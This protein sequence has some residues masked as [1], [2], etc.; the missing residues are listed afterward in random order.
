MPKQVATH[1]QIIAINEHLKKTLVQAGDSTLWEYRAG[2][3]DDTIAA[4]EGVSKNS[5]GNI[6]LKL[7]GKL[8]NQGSSGTD[9]EV[10]KLRAQLVMLTDAHNT[11]CD[12]FTALVNTLAL[13]KVVNVG[14]LK[15]DC[16]KLKAAMPAPVGGEARA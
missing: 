5:V 16:A 12:R 3:S 14:H 7:F 9:E 15:A 4:A 13:N 1:K 2:H 6:R 8:R 10:E 11:L